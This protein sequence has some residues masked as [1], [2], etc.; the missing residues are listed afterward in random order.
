MN[1]EEKLDRLNVYIE[2]Q[3]PNYKLY[4][5]KDSTL[6]RV[7][8]VALFFNKDF[9]T[10]YVTTLYPRV[11]V[12][13]LPWDKHP[14]SQ[15][16]VLAHEYVHLKDRKRLGWFF[17]FLYLSPQILA[18]L[19]FG[20]FWNSWWLLALLFLLP[21]PSPGRA[22]LEYRAYKITIAL[23]WYMTGEVISEFWVRNHFTGPNYYWMFPFGSFLKGAFDREYKK[24]VADDLSPELREIKNVLTTTTVAVYNKFV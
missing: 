7:L 13:E 15:I 21:L 10:G 18:L 3:I 11:Y 2:A 23:H 14:A 19:A 24:I 9:M 5:K 17:N 4:S 12:P 6:M 22:W 8:S 16:S 20:S 1:L